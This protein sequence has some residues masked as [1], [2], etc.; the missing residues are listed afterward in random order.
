M[1]KITIKELKYN[2][3]FRWRDSEKSPIWVRGTY[4]REI[5]KYSCYRYDDVNHEAFLDGT[6]QVFTEGE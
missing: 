3:T 6:K 5:R 1:R 4:V 2:D